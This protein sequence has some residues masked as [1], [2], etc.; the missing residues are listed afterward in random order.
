MNEACQTYECHAS[1]HTHCTHSSSLRRHPPCHA[2]RMNES[3]HTYEWVMSHVSM[4][5]VTQMNESCRTDGRVM[6]HLNGACHTYQW[7]MSHIWSHIVR[8]FCAVCLLKY[9]WHAPLRC[10][11]THSSVWHD[12]FIRVTWLIH[13]CDIYQWVMSQI[14]RECVCGMC[15]GECVQVCVGSVCASVCW[16]CVCKCVLES[17]TSKKD[18]RRARGEQTRQ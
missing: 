3:C 15:V 17:K 18:K 7:V 2:T 4:S 8:V 11:I 6:S 13:T 9:A 1:C 5:H 14:V 10:D 12:S 16:E